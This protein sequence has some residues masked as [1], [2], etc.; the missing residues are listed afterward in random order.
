MDIYSLF[1]CILKKEALKQIVKIINEHS[2]KKVVIGIDNLGKEELL[3]ELA[4][5]FQTKVVE[6]D[7]YD[8]INM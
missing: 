1:F 8:R 3:V 2:G 6:N 7:D 4:K 5:I